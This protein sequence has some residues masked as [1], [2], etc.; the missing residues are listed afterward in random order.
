MPCGALHKETNICWEAV[1]FQ[2]ILVYNELKEKELA[3]LSYLAEW[4]DINDKDKN[5]TCIRQ[6]VPEPVGSPAV[7]SY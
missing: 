1:A 3:K 6:D 7:S 4:L 5:A 2:R